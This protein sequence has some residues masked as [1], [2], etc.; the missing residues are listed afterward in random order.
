MSTQADW[1]EIRLSADDIAAAGAEAR[2]RDDE[3]KRRGWQPRGGA[4]GTLNANRLGALGEVAAARY[5]GLPSFPHR[6]WAEEKQ[7][8][9]DIGGWQVR[10]G[11]RAWYGLYL[12]EHERTGTWVLVLGH[13]APQ[14]VMYLAG[15]IDAA[16][17][18]KH[19]ERRQ[20]E[21]QPYFLVRQMY[22]HPLPPVDR[23]QLAA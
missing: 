15:W 1:I 18:W 8:G 19:A 20:D 2:R 6:T 9:Y 13:D 22:L 7:S 4:G 14:G 21:G 11:T 17:A 16:N 10:T 5:L 12:R 23:H 3:A